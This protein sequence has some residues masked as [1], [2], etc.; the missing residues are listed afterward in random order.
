LNTAKIC[1]AYDVDKLIALNPIELIN[2]FDA[3]DKDPII[4]EDDAQEKALYEI[5]K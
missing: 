4:S 3:S 1:K 5:L 2:Y